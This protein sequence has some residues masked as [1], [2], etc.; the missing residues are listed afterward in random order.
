MEYRHARLEDAMQVAEVEVQG[1]KETYEGILSE[2]RLKRLNKQKIFRIWRARLSRFNPEEEFMFVAIEDDK[3]V[4]FIVGEKF[5]PHRKGN[6]MYKG[7][8]QYE[9]IWKHW[10]LLRKYQNERVG[11]ELI[12][13]RTKQFLDMGVSSCIFAT[14]KDNKKIH[15]MCKHFGIEPIG[16]RT[17]RTGLYRGIT[18]TMFG[19]PDMQ[20][21]YDRMMSLKG[22]RDH[23]KKEG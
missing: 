1:F 2:D 6:S 11:R 12:E 10:Y 3:I 13:R 20:A 15:E 16:E 14:A 21:F 19:V 5:L 23:L 17:A 18:F 22:A 4:G 7:Y 8:E 9:G